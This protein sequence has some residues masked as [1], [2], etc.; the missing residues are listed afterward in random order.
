MGMSNVW[1]MV[2]SP[3]GQCIWADANRIA[4]DT[5][6]NKQ[7][8]EY[9]GNLHY[10]TSLQFWVTSPSNGEVFSLMMSAYAE[11][12]T[13]TYPDVIW[14][15]IIVSTTIAQ[16]AVSVASWSTWWS[17]PEWNLNKKLKHIGLLANLPVTSSH[18][19]GI[20]PLSVSPRTH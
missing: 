20:Q 2:S 6:Y 3:H 10:Y 13:L 11:A 9:I 19:V 15:Y 17:Q 16:R 12:P 18:H 14:C 8:D 4:A 5:E 1:A 7:E